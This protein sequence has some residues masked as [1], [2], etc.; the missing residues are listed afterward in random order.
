MDGVEMRLP[1]QSDPICRQRINAG[2]MEYLDIH[3]SH[4]S[5]F[6]TPSQAKNGQISCIVPMVAHVDQTEHDVQVLV[7]E[8]GLA[9]L[10]GLSP[11]SAGKGNH[12]KLCPS[13]FQTGTSGLP[14]AFA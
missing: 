7:T 13:G 12:R 10:R 8:Q 5:I 9:D 4:V 11:K 1:Y 6:M 2:E 3:L 14:E